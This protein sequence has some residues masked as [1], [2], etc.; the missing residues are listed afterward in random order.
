M[1]FKDK[2]SHA[3]WLENKMRITVEKDLSD[4]M[5]DLYHDN[6]TTRLSEVLEK[7][8]NIIAEYK[9]LCV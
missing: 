1:R 9:S 2:Y 4:A 5:D 7:M 8:E 6:S 3:A